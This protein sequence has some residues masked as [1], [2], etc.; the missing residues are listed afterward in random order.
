MKTLNELLSEYKK[1]GVEYNEE[2]NKITIP[3]SSGFEGMSGTPLKEK[4][5]KEMDENEIDHS[6]LIWLIEGDFDWKS[7]FRAIEAER[8]NDNKDVDLRLV[9]DDKPV[10][11]EKDIQKSNTQPFVLQNM[12]NS[13]SDKIIEILKRYGCVPMGGTTP[14]SHQQNYAVYCPPEKMQDLI[15]E[16]QQIDGV[17]NMF[18]ATPDQ[19]KQYFDNSMPENNSM[20]EMFEAMADTLPE[21]VR[22]MLITMDKVIS[23]LSFYGVILENINE[24]RDASQR[25][26][27]EPGGF[28]ELIKSGKQPVYISVPKDSILL[29]DNIKAAGDDFAK[30]AGKVL[31]RDLFINMPT[32]ILAKVRDEVWDIKKVVDASLVYQVQTSCYSKYDNDYKRVD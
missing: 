17:E 24:L 3:E 32:K 15:N 31:R 11:D 28:A 30:I 27:K 4:L 23:E 16:L 6:N 9:K 1:F 22:T 20:K 12:N 18:V 21:E 14:T 8:K 2:E 13:S 7:Y 5:R 29:Y 10:Y 25:L 26:S 19:A